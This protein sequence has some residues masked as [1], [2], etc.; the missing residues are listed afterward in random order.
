[1]DEMMRPAVLLL[2]L[3]LIDGTMGPA[4]AL[5]PDA[6][7]QAWKSASPDERAKVLEQILGKPGVGVADCMDE[8]S[9]APGHAQL[10]ITEVA[11][12]CA[13]TKKAG[14]PI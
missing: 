6:P 9:V 13:S 4:L 3:L 10:P 8:T 12:A 11:K 2:A 5:E 14:Q 7:M 1:M